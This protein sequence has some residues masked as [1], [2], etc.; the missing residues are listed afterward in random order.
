MVAKADIDWQNLGFDYMPCNYNIRAY[1]KDGK[2]SAL[3]LSS[4]NQINLPMGAACL[5]YGQG[6]FEGLK[7]FEGV[8]G[9]IRV[10]R[11]EDHC[12]RFQSSCRGI[13]MPELPSTLFL[14]AIEE[15]IRLNQSFIPPYGTGASLYLRP[16]MIGLTPN[17]VV[18]PASEFMFILYASPV[19]AYFKTGIKPCK[20][21]IL[22]T[23]DR[24]APLGTGAYKVGGNY[25]AGFSADKLTKEKG[26]ASPIYLDAKEKQYIE[27][28]G[29]ANFFAIKD[30]TY[31]T[32]Q[33]STILP[34]ITNNS[35]MQIAE[36]LGLKVEQ[37]PIHVD[38]LANFDEVGACGTGAVIT[39][40]A[41]IDDLD[42][43]CSFNYSEDKIGT[44]SLNLYRHLQGIQYGEI[45]DEHQ[46]NRIYSL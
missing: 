38:E 4:D 2:W 31:L 37:R 14:E 19:G 20:M 44:I 27:E 36:D 24:A 3:E 21:A 9:L 29:A 17:V 18:A 40:I 25:A 45:E 34:S 5:H 12:K 11:A 26:Y 10:F 15:V 46:W 16:M 32:P 7:A 43:A 6:A 42:N 23:Y 35:L 39:P 30:K 13:A 1:Y 33:S 28:C 22:R 8:D 41:Q